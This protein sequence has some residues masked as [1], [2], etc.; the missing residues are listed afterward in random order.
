MTTLLKKPPLRWSVLGLA[1]ALAVAWAVLTRAQATAS[2]PIPAAALSGVQ[3]VSM[4]D[5]NVD[6][7]AQGGREPAAG[8]LPFGGHKA[9]LAFASPIGGW[10]SGFDY[11]NEIVLYA[12]HDGG[13]T[14]ARQRVTAPGEYSTEGGAVETRSP[15]FFGEGS[16]DGLLPVVFHADGQPIVFHVTHD[17]GATWQ[18]TTAVVS[19][20]NNSFVW[21]FADLRHAFAPDGDRLYATGDGAMSWQAVIPNVSLG[22]VSQL[23]FVSA[24]TGWAVV[25]GSLVKTTDGGRTWTQPAT[26]S[27]D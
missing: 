14:W 27:G 8:S 5:E 1:L 10:V 11:G 22:G 23:D 7:C 24:R 25:G 19:A 20:V 16:P 15:I 9:G 4:V 3:S 26:G 13:R 12:S 2:R 21:S 18:P 17:G 6:D